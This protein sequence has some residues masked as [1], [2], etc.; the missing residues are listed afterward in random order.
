M[1]VQQYEKYKK[2]NFIHRKLN[3]TKMFLSNL[4][5]YLSDM[6][7]GTEITLVTGNDVDS[8]PVLSYSLQLDPTSLGKFG[9]HRYSGGVSLTAPLDFEEK[10]WYTLT[11]RATDSQHQTEANITILVEDINDNAPAFTQDL[12]Q[13]GWFINVVLV[14]FSRYIDYIHGTKLNMCCANVFLTKSSCTFIPIFSNCFVCVVLSYVHHN[15][16]VQY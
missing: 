3:A 9:I 15:Y 16:S 5:L 8:S 2:H 13:V 7:I 6:L 12:Y 1:A 14:F 11:V 4:F 10:T